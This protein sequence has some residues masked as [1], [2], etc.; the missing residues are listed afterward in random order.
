MHFIKPSPDGQSPKSPLILN[1]FLASS[2]AS[3][4]VV[5]GWEGSLGIGGFCED[6]VVVAD[7][8]IWRTLLWMIER[9]KEEAFKI[10]C[11]FLCMR[12]AWCRKIL[13]R[14]SNSFE[15]S[16]FDSLVMPTLSFV[17]GKQ[18][19]HKAKKL[20]SIVFHDFFFEKWQSRIAPSKC[21]TYT[22]TSKIYI[23]IIV[24]IFITIFSYT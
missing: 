17:N 15:W 7:A 9:A 14:A 19:K 3:C 16:S 2:A 18:E 6:L 12:S 1:C 21:G 24:F 22:S 5:T 20:F 10:S 4:W 11:S 13:L 8:R 23:H